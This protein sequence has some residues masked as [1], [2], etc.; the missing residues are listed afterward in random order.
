MNRQLCAKSATAQSETHYT[1][2]RRVRTVS[3]AQ[4]HQL[5][6]ARTEGR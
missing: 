5:I 6:D 2:E 3:R 4:I 1:L